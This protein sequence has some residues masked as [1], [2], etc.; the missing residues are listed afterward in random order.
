MLGTRAKLRELSYKLTKYPRN[1]RRVSKIIIRLANGVCERCGKTGYKL[2]VHHM[3]APY[4]D[5][6]PGNPHDKHD[7]RRENLTAICTDCHDELEHVRA[8]RKN[9]RKRNKRRAARFEAHRALGLGT[10]LVPFVDC[11]PCWSY[12]S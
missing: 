9:K 12:A 2:E 7:I 5:G 8:I 6:R 3:G 4:A 11:T 1:Q 10:G